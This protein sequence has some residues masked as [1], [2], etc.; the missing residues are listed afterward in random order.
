LIACGEGP[1]GLHSA[2]LSFAVIR[3]SPGFT[4]LN[5]TGSVA[6]A[7]SSSFSVAQVKYARAGSAA[8]GRWDSSYPGMAKGGSEARRQPF[9]GCGRQCRSR[10]K[11]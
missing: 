5:A 7:I 3:V 8:C 9:N 2:A 11:N 4:R 6:T 1:N 10:I